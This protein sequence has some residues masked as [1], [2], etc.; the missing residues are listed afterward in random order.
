MTASLISGI[1]P[2]LNPVLVAVFYGEKIGRLALV[3][4]VDK[5][6]PDKGIKFETYVSKRIRGAIIDL[7]RRQKLLICRS[8]AL[9]VY[10]VFLED[11]AQRTDRTP[12]TPGPQDTRTR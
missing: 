9:S 5:F 10:L 12:R 1:E 11:A 2:V 4:A 3:G 8:C 7:A 6:D